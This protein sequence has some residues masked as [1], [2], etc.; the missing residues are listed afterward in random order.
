MP[1]DPDRFR[2]TLGRLPTGITVV[3]LTRPDGAGGGASSLGTVHGITVNSFTSLSL[4][5]PLVGVA[6]DVRARAHAMLPALARYGVSILSA[7]QSPVSD[8]FA[9]RPVPLADDP[10]EELDGH[11]VVRGAAAQLVCVVVDQ[12]PVGDHTLVVGRVDH[13]RVADSA[14]LAYVRGRYGRVEPV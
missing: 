3:S 5:P 11:P 4:V 12:V 7:D 10:F 1:I 2:Q 13:A 6:I 14:A 8:H 9:G